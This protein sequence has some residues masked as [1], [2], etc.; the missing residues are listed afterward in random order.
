MIF[1][2]SRARVSCGKLRYQI[3]EEISQETLL[4]HELWNFLTASHPSLLNQDLLKT[5]RK[6]LCRTSCKRLEGFM[7]GFVQG[8]DASY[9]GPRKPVES[10]SAYIWLTTNLCKGI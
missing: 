3:G 7:R 5:S 6:A 10:T 8:Q 1:N 9:E 2:K 4:L